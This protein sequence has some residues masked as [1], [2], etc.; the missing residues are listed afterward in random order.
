MRDKAYRIQARVADE[1]GHWDGTQQAA[2]GFVDTN[3]LPRDLHNQ[4]AVGG[5]IHLRSITVGHARLASGQTGAFVTVERAHDGL[6][7][8]HCSKKKQAQGDGQPPQ[9]EKLAIAIHCSTS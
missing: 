2:I 4:L 6:R 9:S 3:V 8:R 7:G 5:H 1:C